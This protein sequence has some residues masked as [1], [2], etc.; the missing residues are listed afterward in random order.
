MKINPIYRK[1]IIAR[2][3]SIKFPIT[4]F[5]FNL[6]LIAI[7]FFAFEISF[8]VYVNSGVD[9]IN[10]VVIY[11]VIIFIEAGMLAVMIPAFTAG[12]IAGEREKQTLEILLTTTLKPVQIVVGKLVSSISMALLLVASSLPVISVVFTVGG[13]GM[14]DLWQFIAAM[15]VFSIF[16]GSMGVWASAL[17][18]KTVSATVLSFAMVFAVC[19]LTAVAVLLANGAANVY[20]YNF[21]NPSGKYPDVSVFTYIL[22]LNP[23]FTMAEICLRQIG[24]ES[25]ASVV[26]SALNGSLPAV[27][28][29]HWVLFSLIVQFACSIL[30][31][32][33]ASRHLNPLKKKRAG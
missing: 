6:V 14:A 20:H 24:E 8:N 21:P 11:Y 4:I 17:V 2:A 12:S 1:E 23:A 15:V 32:C 18:K 9:Y 3:R 27:F 25:I 19:I 5:V 26:S 13:V 10:A 31:V 33:F 28:Q 16:I 22:L 30:F 7:E 29:D